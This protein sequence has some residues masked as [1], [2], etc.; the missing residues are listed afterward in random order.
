[1]T[2]EGEKIHDPAEGQRI[3]DTQVC[4]R[5]R[6]YGHLL[7]RACTSA[8]Y[9][10]ALA[11]VRGCSRDFAEC[12]ITS[13]PFPVREYALPSSPVRGRRCDNQVMT[14]SERMIRQD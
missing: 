13:L 14:G 11:A 9:T 10:H 4:I 1:M 7:V 6:W 5:A 12:A 2:R 3:V 8:Q